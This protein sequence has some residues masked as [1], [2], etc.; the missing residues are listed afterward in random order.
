MMSDMTSYTR[1]QVY[2]DP[3]DH[4]RLQRLAAER[5]HSMTDL[6]RE[7]VAHYIAD[8]LDDDLP[9]MDALLEELYADERYAGIP[10]GREGFVARMRARAEDDDVAGRIDPQDRELGDALR[11]E[12]EVRRNAWSRRHGSARGPNHEG[13]P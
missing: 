6:V 5:G 12:H 9:T 8:E 13:G 10:S 3:D 7:A 1:T 2:L 4:R 11:R